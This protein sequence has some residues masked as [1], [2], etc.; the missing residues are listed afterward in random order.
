AILQV[1]AAFERLTGYARAQALGRHAASL[2]SARHDPDFFQRV[3]AAA[4]ERGYWE[5]EMW[6]SRANGDLFPA[7]MTL[8]AVR[9]AQ[10]PTVNYAMS[11]VDISERKQ[12]EQRIRHLAYHDLL[13]D[14][15]NRALMGER[16]GAAIERARR[17][18][19][20]VALLFVD[21]DRFEHI[22]DSLG[23]HGGDQALR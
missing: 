4:E 5:G 9:G 18:G 10:G 11:F 13:T 22:N 16:V 20:K 14:L 7:F 2:A 1:N 3:F 21:V 19:R 17:D 8:S 23:H 6:Q 12:A 15:P